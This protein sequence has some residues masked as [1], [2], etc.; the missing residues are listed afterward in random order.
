MD[1]SLKFTPRGGFINITIES[2]DKS[3]I[4]SIE[5]NGCG[6]ETSDLQRVIDK[7]YKSNESKSGCGLDLNIKEGQKMK[8]HKSLRIFILCS[9]FFFSSCSL[10]TS[11]EET[12]GPPRK[13]SDISTDN[14]DIYSVIRG[15][16]KSQDKII[17][18]DEKDK[19][20]CYYLMDIDG[21]NSEEVIT[22]YEHLNSL[23]EYRLLVLKKAIKIG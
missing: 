7:F 9:V 6:I 4:I 15:F 8:L 20:K 22:V 14:T 11:P 16:I 13:E 23:P 5:D 2:S 18:L 10:L 17:S 12:V 19:S 1:N 3:L 21:D